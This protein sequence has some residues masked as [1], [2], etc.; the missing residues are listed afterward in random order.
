MP[1]ASTMPEH[2]KLRLANNDREELPRSELK[3]SVTFRFGTAR[4]K[5]LS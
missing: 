3:P 2:F 1:L 5:D 4:R